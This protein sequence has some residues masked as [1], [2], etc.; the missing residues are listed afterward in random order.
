MHEPA[1]LSEQQVTAERLAELLRQEEFLAEVDQ[2]GDVRV[3]TEEGTFVYIAVD[4]VRRLLKFYTAYRFR[5][6][7]PLSGKLS[8]V[9][10][11]ND[12]V[13]FTR[14][15]VAASDILLADYF[16]SYDGG[17]LCHQLVRSLAWFSRVVVGAIANFDED[18][19]VQ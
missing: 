17:L 4:E 15:S 8:L 1:I 19:L 14:F 12:E 2:D 11:M 18:D 7:A 9:N 13:V 6:N 5:P 16:L 3:A 10:R